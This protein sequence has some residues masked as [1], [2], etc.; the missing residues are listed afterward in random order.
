MYDEEIAARG[1]GESERRG[2][3]FYVFEAL[4]YGPDEACKLPSGVEKA[5]GLAEDGS[6]KADE[7]IGREHGDRVVREEGPLGGGEEDA[8][9]DGGDEG[10]DAEVA[11]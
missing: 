6:D 9:D 4:G 11:A 3:L 8:A 5:E 10:Q 2:V 7:E 1:G